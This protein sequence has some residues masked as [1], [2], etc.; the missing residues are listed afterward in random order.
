[1]VKRYSPNSIFKT[2]DPLPGSLTTQVLVSL[3]KH[4]QSSLYLNRGQN[5]RF[6][7]NMASGHPFYL[8]TTPGTG[9][10]TFMLMVSQVMVLKLVLSPSKFRSTHRI[11]ST[12]SVPTTDPWWVRLSLTLML[13]LVFRTMEHWLVLH[14]VSTS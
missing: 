9:T 4:T 2:M 14:P 5:Y 3:R 7:V 10:S 1:M 12:I 6:N 8:K 13:T 11:H